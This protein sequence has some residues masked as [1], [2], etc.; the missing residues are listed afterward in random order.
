MVAGN[1]SFEGCT[2]CPSEHLFVNGSTFVGGSSVYPGC[3]RFHEY[4]DVM[5]CVGFTRVEAPVQCG[6]FVWWRPLLSGASLPGLNPVW[7]CG[8]LSNIA[9]RHFRERLFFT[10]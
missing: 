8:P 7:L 6:F 4:V 10:F 1:C 9:C 3:G 5:C 2:T